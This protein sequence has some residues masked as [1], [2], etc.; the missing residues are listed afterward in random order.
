MQDIQ[1]HHD[2]LGPFRLAAVLLIDEAVQ[3]MNGANHGNKG[4]DAGD[5]RERVVPGITLET[6]LGGE[7][8]ERAFRSALE[9]GKAEGAM[10]RLG[11]G[12]LG[13]GLHHQRAGTHGRE[14]RPLVP[15]VRV[16][17]GGT[18]GAQFGGRLGQFDPRLFRL[19]P[20]GPGN[21]R[22]RIGLRYGAVDG[23]SR[24]LAHLF[25]KRCFHR[26]LSRGQYQLEIGAGVDVGARRPDAPFHRVDLGQAHRQGQAMEVDVGDAV[27]RMPVLENAEHEALPWSH[28]ERVIE[29]GAA[30][31]GLPVDSHRQGVMPRGGL[32]E[33]ADGVRRLGR[34]EGDRGSMMRPW[35]AVVRDDMG[36]IAAEE[37]SGLEQQAV[38]W[39]WVPAGDAPAQRAAPAREGEK[40]EPGGI[41]GLGDPGLP[42]ALAEGQQDRRIGDPYA[43]VGEG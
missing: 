38:A 19:V 11:L 5:A 29:K 7:Q 20:V 33:S 14:S 42:V 43:V 23:K 9:S 25:Q 6:R 34:L 24:S 2:G 40:A 28:M 3:R 22:G 17:D 31:D 4:L 18:P 16:G 8:P 32:K 41:F 26:F 35:G 27:A 15:I 39:A 30:L 10:K 13:V 1:V 21:P 37:V 36:R 12:R